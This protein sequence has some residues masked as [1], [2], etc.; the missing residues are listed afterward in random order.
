[1]AQTWCWA[2]VPKARESQVASTQVA[3]S[4]TMKKVWIV[5]IYNNVNPPRVVRRPG[6]VIAR[7]GQDMNEAMAKKLAEEREKNKGAEVT[8]EPR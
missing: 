7:S 3:S 6:M 5:I 1:M 2:I 4:A 8:L